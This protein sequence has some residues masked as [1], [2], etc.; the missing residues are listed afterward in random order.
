MEN[1]YMENIESI[2]KKAK[3]EKNESLIK[4]VEF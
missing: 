3:V 4:K 2:S 1:K